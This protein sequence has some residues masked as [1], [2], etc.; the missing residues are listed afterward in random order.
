MKK[1]F[2]IT[3]IS[4]VIFFSCEDDEAIRVPELEQAV[5]MRV[6]VNPEKSFL[7][8]ANLGTAEVE[9]DL[10]TVSS[11]VD[12]V[13][14][15]VT[16]Q[17]FRQDS[18]YDQVLWQTFQYG[19]FRDVGQGFRAIEDVTLSTQGLLDLY[20]IASADTLSG[21]DVLT[22]NVF[23]TTVDGDVY[24]DT[25]LTGTDFESLNIDVGAFG[26]GSTSSL[27]SGFIAFV[28]CPTDQTLW[29]GEYTTAVSNVDAFCG[30]L[31]CASTRDASVGYVGTPEPFRYTMT[32]H[33]AGLWG[34]FDPGSLDRAG[35]F[36]DICE[37][38][39]LLPSATGYG[40]HEDVGGGSRDPDTGVFFYN[41]CNFFN[42]VCG[43]TTFT[44]KT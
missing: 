9:F 5:T 27:S 28:A 29:E 40:D 23:T 38:P 25:V 14:I 20:N 3:L 17:N 26:I 39:L 32:T 22:F 42:P 35:A 24:P 33:D 18:T 19:E 43:T 12:K 7:D 21:G 36:Y 30:L 11:F 44:P 31:D 15:F 13:D 37:S 4:S 2:L 8:F 16:Y 1:L 6:Q 41:W 34:S 10:Y